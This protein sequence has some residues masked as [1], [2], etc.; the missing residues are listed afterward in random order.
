MIFMVE[1]LHSRKNRTK[2]MPLIFDLLALR[3]LLPL[4]M[5]K[6]DLS[7]R[8]SSLPPDPHEHEVPLSTIPSTRPGSVGLAPL[9]I[10][11]AISMSQ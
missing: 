7:S 3:G 9:S 2:C 1:A 5:R 8:M 10:L 11:T 4:L 6:L